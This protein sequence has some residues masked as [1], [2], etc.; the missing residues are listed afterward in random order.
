MNISSLALECWYI[1]LGGGVLIGRI[2]QFLLASALWIGYV[3]CIFLRLSPFWFSFSL[4]FWSIRRIDQPF[5][6]PNVGVFGYHF[7]Y[8]PVCKYLQKLTGSRCHE[9]LFFDLSVPLLDFQKELLVHD[10]HRH[11]FLERISAMYL[12]KLRYKNFGTDAGSCWRQIFVVTLMPW[13]MKYHVIYEKRCFDALRDVASEA[14]VEYEENK[15]FTQD[16]VGLGEN[17]RDQAIYGVVGAGVEGMQ[18]VGEVGIATLQKAI[19]V[20]ELVMP[21][22]QHSYDDLKAEGGQSVTP[23]K[24]FHGDFQDAPPHAH[25]EPPTSP[26]KHK[27]VEPSLLP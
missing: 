27:D 7:D 10:A 3:E 14:K 5:L 15:D 11:P 13:L 4:D 19:S 8:V 26:A 2:T 22:N 17:V 12:M 18:I 24:S 9:H 16:V 21:T 20:K 6:A 23:T 25:Q 1:G